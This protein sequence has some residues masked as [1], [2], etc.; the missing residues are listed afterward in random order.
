M[1]LHGTEV[2]RRSMLAGAVS[3]V[4]LP[5]TARM[6]HATPESMAEAMTEALGTGAAPQVGRVKVELPGLAENGNSVPLRVSVESPMTA[7]DHV[8]TIYVFSRR[9]TPSR[10]WCVFT[11][12]PARA[13]P[14][15]KRLLNL[16]GRIQ[17]CRVEHQKAEPLAY[18]SQALLALT[19]VVAHQSR[20]LPLKVA[21]DGPA[22]PMFEAAAPCFS[23]SKA[24]SIFR[25]PNATTTIG[26]NGCAPSASARATPTASPPIGW[27]GKPSARCIGA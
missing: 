11:S 7:A 15:L 21:T 9:R 4:V 17:N 26:A 24:S 22:R 23:R 5:L 6:A 2:S 13:A 3:I 14:R 1:T 19:A 20:G 10:M 18:E 16:E 27:N 12:G 25:A 8:K